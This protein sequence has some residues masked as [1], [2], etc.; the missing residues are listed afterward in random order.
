[1]VNSA[2]DELVSGLELHRPGVLENERNASAQNQSHIHRGCLVHPG[3]YVL[4]RAPALEL[5]EAP[6]RSILGG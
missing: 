2:Q 6:R 4:R 3:R 1:V 5:D